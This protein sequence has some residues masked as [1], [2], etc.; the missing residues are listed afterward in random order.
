MLEFN[1]LFDN[2]FKVFLPEIYVITLT[3]FLIIVGV[4][5]SNL[6]KY[7]YSYYVKEMS[8]FASS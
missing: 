8:I 7:D 2:H 6:K 4:S 3:L 5:I 1:I